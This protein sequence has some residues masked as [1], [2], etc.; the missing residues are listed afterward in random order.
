MSS[1]KLEHWHFQTSP[2]DIHFY[3]ILM[4]KRTK[5]IREFFEYKFTLTYLL[6]D[7][8]PIQLF[9]TINIAYPAYCLSK[10]IFNQRGVMFTTTIRLP[11]LLQWLSN[12]ECKIQSL[13]NSNWPAF[14]SMTGTCAAHRQP[15]F[16]WDQLL[17]RNNCTQQSQTTSYQHGLVT[18]SL[19]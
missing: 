1:I 6:T 18:R 8:S 3:E 7:H 16:H 19:S 9:S 17:L 14:G 13:C 11:T 2:E 5:R 4:T 15:A 12:S 10:P